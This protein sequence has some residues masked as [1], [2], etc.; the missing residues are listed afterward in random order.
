[1]EDCFLVHNSGSVVIL[2]GQQIST[3]WVVCVMLLMLPK[4]ERLV[5]ISG[6]VK[7]YVTFILLFLLFLYDLSLYSLAQLW[8]DVCGCVVTTSSF[9][10]KSRTQVDC[11]WWVILSGQLTAEVQIH[12]TGVR[13][14]WDQSSVQA[15]KNVYTRHLV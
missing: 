6:L 8:P 13:W 7:P 4:S 2:W 15:C 14:S 10:D 11:W 1:L 3:A 12:P 5:D 9:L